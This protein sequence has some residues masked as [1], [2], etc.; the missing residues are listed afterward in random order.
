MPINETLKAKL[1]NKESKVRLF[2]R[3]AGITFATGTTTPAPGTN[4]PAVPTVIG[5]KLS[6][7]CIK[8]NELSE[9]RGGYVVRLLPGSA[10]PIKNT[11]ALFHHDWKQPVASLETCSLILTPD[12]VGVKFEVTLLA[13]TTTSRDLYEN[14][15]T[16]LVKGMS[17]CMSDVI[18]AVEKVEDGQNIM[19]VSEFEYDEITFTAC[20]AFTQTTAEIVPGEQSAD[21]TDEGDDDPPA[22]VGEVVSQHSKDTPDLTADYLKAEQ[23]RLDMYR[24]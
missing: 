3:D 1:F 9:D 24:L 18:E 22:P 4:A 15:R 11:Y 14:V 2:T 23:Y 7:Y 13:D 19:E 8:W 10:A 6:G 21:D 20:P 12:D 5:S 16:K 17:F